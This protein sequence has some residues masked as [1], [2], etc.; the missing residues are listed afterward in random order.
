MKMRIPEKLLSLFIVTMIVSGAASLTSAATTVNDTI[1]RDTTW[2]ARKSPYVVTENILLEHGATL[3]IKPGVRVE[4]AADKKI[5]IRGKLIAMG[6]LEKPITFTAHTDAPWETLYFTDFCEDATFSESGVYKDGCILKHCIIEKGH[7]VYVRFGAPLI[8]ECTVRNNVSS[9]IR[10][11]FGGPHIVRNHITGNSTEHDPASGN[12]G[13]IIAYTDK[14]L[15]I[16]DNIINNNVSD[17]G[18]DGGGGIYAYASGEGR[19]VVSNNTVFGNTSSRFGGGVYAYNS[20]LSGNTIIGNTAAERG[21]GIYAVESE[22]SGNA[23]Q[24]NTAPRG[25]GICA[26]NSDITANSIIR[27]TASRPEGGALYYFGSR[28]VRGNCI[29]SNDAEGEHACGGIYVSGN[30][31]IG[32]NN[33]FNNAGFA[34]YVANVADAPEVSAT[35]NYWGTPSDKAILGL[36]YDWLDDENAGLAQFLPFRQAI[37]TNAPAPPPFNLM[38]AVDKDGIRLS[39]DEPAGLHFDGHRVY[40]GTTSGY[41]YEKVIEAGPETHYILSGIEPGGE[42]WIAVAGYT[43]ADGRKIESGFSGEVHLM[44]TD[45]SSSTMALETGS[46]AAS[47]VKSESITLKVSPAARVAGIAES[48]WQVSA[49]PDDFTALAVDAITTGDDLFELSLADAQLPK[50]S[51]YFWRMAHRTATGSWSSWSS[52]A[53]FRLADDD[54]S[55]L[56]GPLTTMTLRKRLSPY[57]MTGNTLVMTDATLQIEPGVEV[58]VGPGRNL[59]IRGGIVARGTA[60]EPIVFTQESSE[61]WG[62]I[63][64]SD[65]SQP[66]VLNED[67]SYKNGCVLEQCII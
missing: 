36:I 26:E 23:V 21:G 12:G 55:V 5:E 39:W 53:S 31:D 24:S 56:S 44:A 50:G 43:R 48:R 66:V 20:V 10:I 17:G 1:S 40:V 45:F 6:T 29:V 62:Q 61:H 58:R 54:P 38:A 67:G 64:F 3:T 9:G 14:N 51:E 49:F 41:P 15:L 46:G 33:L 57:R 18:R 59:L 19:I 2:A 63:L 25:G 65:T 27:N 28:T 22:L 7:G 47:T 8:T 13:G 37:G 16:A 34:L 30:P 35:E 52:P 42:Y 60:S 11:E 4:L 32:D